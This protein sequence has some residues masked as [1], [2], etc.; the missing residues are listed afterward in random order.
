MIRVIR[1]TIFN[2]GFIGFT[3]IY[4]A[5]IA[6]ITPFLSTFPQKYKFSSVWFHGMMW[7][8]KWGGNMDCIIEGKENI[9]DT[10]MVLLSNHQS[11]WETFSLQAIFPMQRT[12]VKKEL[13]KVPIFG[14]ALACLSP[15]AIDRS[16]GSEAMEKLINEGREALN[17]GYWV[18]IFPQGTRVPPGETGKFNMGGVALAHETGYPILPVAH[19]A[20]DFWPRRGFMKKPGTIR[21]VIGKPIYPEGLNARQMHRQSKNWINETSLRLHEEQKAKDA[22]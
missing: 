21:L 6:A 4:S 22:Q 14:W 11:S 7:W 8:S 12:V 10:P 5:L 15:I 16:K 1:S 13:L 19:N 3:I 9:P 20:G 2:I 17:T 18:A